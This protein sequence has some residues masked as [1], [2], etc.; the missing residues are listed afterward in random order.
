MRVLGANMAWLLKLMEHGK[1][2]IPQPT[3][4]EKIMTNFIR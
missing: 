1:G 3:M 2:K 4:E